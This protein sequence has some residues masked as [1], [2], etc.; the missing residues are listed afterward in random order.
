MAAHTSALLGARGGTHP[1][2]LGGEKHPPGAADAAL[3]DEPRGDGPKQTAL[4]REVSE[5]ARSPPALAGGHESHA[6]RVHGEAVRYYVDPLALMVP[7]RVD[8]QS[9][10]S[11]A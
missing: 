4:R 11:L 3:R 9:V 7:G 2:D 1:R 10:N 6:V 5:P 8:Q